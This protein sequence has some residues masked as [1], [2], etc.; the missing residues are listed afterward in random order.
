MDNIDLEGTRLPMPKLLTTASCEKRLEEDFV[1]NRLS[2]P[3]DDPIRQLKHK[4]AVQEITGESLPETMKLKA[5]DRPRCL[6]S[7]S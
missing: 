3:P 4:R 5:T 7:H 1:L 6:A 2:C